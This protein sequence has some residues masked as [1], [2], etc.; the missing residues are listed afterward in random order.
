MNKEQT[1]KKKTLRFFV[2]DENVGIE[3][4][5]NFLWDDYIFVSTCFKMFRVMKFIVSVNCW[6]FLSFDDTSEWF[7]KRH[8]DAENIETYEV[9]V[10]VFVC[11]SEC[12]ITIWECQFAHQKK[13][14][15]IIVWRCVRLRIAHR[16]IWIGALQFVFVCVT[17]SVWMF[18]IYVTSR[19]WVIVIFS[20]LKITI[21]KCSQNRAK[22]IFR[23]WFFSLYIVFDFE[24]SIYDWDGS[25]ICF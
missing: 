6:S 8:F 16:Y 23:S 25:V 4:S 17:L 1:N 14:S 3:R 19:A 18:W 2:Y 12:L 9:S 24:H 13:K 20:I 10:I 7:P 15:M 5:N 22:R 11:V 21:R